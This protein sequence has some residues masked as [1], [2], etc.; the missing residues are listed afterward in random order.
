ME[1][2]SHSRKEN[3]FIKQNNQT[4][5][6]RRWKRIQSHLKEQNNEESFGRVLESYY[7]GTG[8]KAIGLDCKPKPDDKPSAMEFDAVSARDPIFY[9]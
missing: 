2:S 7:H 5:I 3:C 8:H 6:D 4:K 9:R 1:N